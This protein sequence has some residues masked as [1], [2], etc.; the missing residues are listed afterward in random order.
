[1]IRAIE[2]E[3]FKCF[4]RLTL[5]LAPLTLLT[6]VNAGGKS[7]V[8]QALL[9]LHQGI[10]ETAGARDLVLSGPAI[11]LGTLRDVVDKVNGR[12]RFAIGLRHDEVT[13][14][15]VFESASGDRDDLSV[16]VASV[17]WE[18]SSGRSTGEAR[19]RPL[20]VP[21]GLRDETAA[22]ALLRALRSIQH[23]PAARIGPSEVFPLED[24]EKHQTFGPRAER[25]IGALYWYGTHSVRPAVRHPAESRPM[26]LHQLE[27]WLGE[28]FPGASLDV[29]RVRGANLVSLGIR[30][31]LDTD[32]HRPQHVGFGIT[33]VLPV[34]IACLTAGEGQLVL[35]ENPE[36]HLHPKAQAAV[37]RFLAQIGASG[38]QVV[39]ESHSDH[40]LN[41]VRRAVRDGLIDAS[42]VQ[43][44]FF[45]PRGDTS[46]AQVVSPR[47]NAEGRIEHWPEGFFDQIEND[48]MILAGL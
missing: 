33:H 14:R 22:A 34:L 7:T 38:T 24:A 47:I 8:Q 36:T 26:L 31:S 41:G 27:A 44:H 19:G 1:V 37:G 18:S 28:L 43:I 10:S 48:T 13:V 40:V 4:E 30:T 32:F 23:V 21:D 46:R 12:S 42:A 35:I 17:V 9:L 39:L 45:R 11:V 5:P 29:Q 15:W 6:G 16:P 3:T 2:L 20:V 25:S